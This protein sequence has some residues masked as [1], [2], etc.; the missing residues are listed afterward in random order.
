MEEAISR[1]MDGM[2]AQEHGGF[3]DLHC[4]LGRLLMPIVKA[5]QAMTHKDKLKGSFIQSMTEEEQKRFT[6]SELL[7]YKHALFQVQTSLI[8]VHTKNELVHTSSYQVHMS[9]Y[10]VPTVPYIVRT[11]YIQYLM[12]LST[13]GLQ[14]S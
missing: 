6:P 10:L 13:G 1:F 14:L 3:N 11:Q 12:V 2:E 5:G 4:L 9:T 7:L 8:A